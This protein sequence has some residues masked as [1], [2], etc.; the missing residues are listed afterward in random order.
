ME[1][2]ITILLAK[3]AS[4]WGVGL[5]LSP[6]SV[7]LNE[8]EEPTPGVALSPEKARLLAHN[9]IRFADDLESRLPPDSILR[10]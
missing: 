8:K 3:T 2:D 7:Y 9:L 10:Q 6:G 5:S 4:G 1:N